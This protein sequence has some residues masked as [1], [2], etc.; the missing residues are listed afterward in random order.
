MHPDGLLDTWINSIQADSDKDYKNDD[1]SNANTTSTQNS[2]LQ[3]TFPI[4]APSAA[5]TVSIPMS[6]FNS[7]TYFSSS[8]IAATGGVGHSV[9]WNSPFVS[10][11][12]VYEYDLCML[13]KPKDYIGLCSHCH[14]QIDKEVLASPDTCPICGCSFSGIKVFSDF[15]GQGMKKFHEYCKNEDNVH[16]SM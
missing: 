7:G 14:S 2:T 11:S 4:I 3:G 1:N 5:T 9:V 10:T 13:I 12:F 15:D 6:N 8:P 16:A